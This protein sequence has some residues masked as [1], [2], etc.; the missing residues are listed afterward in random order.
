MKVIDQYKNYRLVEGDADSSYYYRLYMLVEGE[1]EF[2]G[3]V[4]CKEGF[5]S[6]VDAFEEE[7]RVEAAMWRQHYGC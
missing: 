7:M 1:P 4:G 3:Y 2:I 5:L 6:A